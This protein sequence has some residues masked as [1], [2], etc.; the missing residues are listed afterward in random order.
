VWSRSRQGLGQVSG[1][2]GGRRQWPVC[3]ATCEGVG[4]R[5]QSPVGLSPA[6]AVPVFGGIF[7]MGFCGPE[8]RG[9]EVAISFGE[10]HSYT[11][12]THPST[13]L[14]TYGIYICITRGRGLTAFIGMPRA[15]GFGLRACK[16]ALG[17]RIWAP[18]LDWRPQGPE[19]LDLGGPRPP[20]GGRH[21]PP[22]THRGVG[23]DGMGP[24]WPS[25]AAFG[26]HQPPPA[27]SWH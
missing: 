25:N 1:F 9:R 19:I 16:C 26:A 17:R 14:P 5:A 20:H 2:P 8:T 4:R 24:I 12:A 3:V 6:N 15:R 27:D 10:V 13:A 23:G 7:S 11:R 18:V 21:G 22:V